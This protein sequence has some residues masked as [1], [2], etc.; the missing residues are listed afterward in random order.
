[1]SERES[2]VAWNPFLP[3]ENAAQ[4]GPGPQPDRPGRVLYVI[5]MANRIGAAHI[6][7]ERPAGCAWRWD[8]GER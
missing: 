3:A 8:P 6:R 5:R 7:T 1:M 4:I 2:V